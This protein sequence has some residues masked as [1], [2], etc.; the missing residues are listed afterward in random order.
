MLYVSIELNFK[1]ILI[2]KFKEKNGYIMHIN[3]LILKLTRMNI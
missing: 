2:F 1:S 3:G